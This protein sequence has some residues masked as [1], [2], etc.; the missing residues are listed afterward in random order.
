MIWLALGLAL[1]VA[2]AVGLYSRNWKRA[3]LIGLGVLVLG[4]IAA[5]AY[6]YMEWWVITNS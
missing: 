2:L 4:I 5:V 6:I 3:L 1:I